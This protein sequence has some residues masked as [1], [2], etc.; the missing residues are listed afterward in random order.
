MVCSVELVVVCLTL[1]LTF[2]DF[3]ELVVV[4]VTLG[5][6]LLDWC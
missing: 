4:C 1:E 6:T 2:W 5:L 3:G